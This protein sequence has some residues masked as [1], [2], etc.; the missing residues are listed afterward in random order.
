MY[1]ILL[2]SDVNSSHTQ[3][4]VLALAERGIE[5]GI[6]SLN[7]LF[8]KI[9]NGKKNITIFT[10][11]DLRKG[12]FNR[13][14][15]FKSAYLGSLPLLKKAIKEFNPDIVH[16]H[17]ASSYGL[18]GRLAHFNPFIISVWGSDVFDFP[19]KNM[20]SKQILKKNLA[21]ADY[22]LSTSHVMA[23]ETKQYTTRYIEV[24]PFGINLDAFKPGAGERV[25]EE[26]TLVIGTVKTL[27]EI[28]NIDVLIRAF[29][30]VYKDFKNIR[31]LIVGEGSQHNKL[32]HL[33]KTLGIENIVKFTGYIPADRVAGYHNAIDIFVNAAR[34]ES[35]GVSVI[36]ASACGKPVIV[37][38]VGGLTEVVEDKVSGIMV[39]AGDAEQ[40]SGAI[41][42]LVANKQ[43]RTE[44]GL[45]GRKRVEKLY[46]WKDNVEQMITVYDNIIKERK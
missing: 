31:L 1:R 33:V 19:A 22:I 24:I 2:L 7:P 21:A 41:K 25:F 15:L 34:H 26:G 27:E 39:T 43:M 30:N 9:F 29:A 44:L 35:F 37:S 8:T 36:E 42:M 32:E 46:N 45:N 23:E 16:A 18:L 4:W 6:F 14:L 10:G 5:V 17:Y 11:K 13:A 3:K 40:L 38:K 12:F 20:L 28:Y